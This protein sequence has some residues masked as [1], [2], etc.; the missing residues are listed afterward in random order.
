MSAE[1]KDVFGHGTEEDLTLEHLGYQ[2]AGVHSVV[3][4]SLE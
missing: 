3:Y 4:S 1:P 2:Q